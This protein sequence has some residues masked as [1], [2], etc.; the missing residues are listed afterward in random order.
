MKSSDLLEL[1]ELSLLDLIEAA[2]FE[3]GHSFRETQDEAFRAYYDYITSGDYTDSEKL[4]GFFEI[5]T[6][7]GKTGIISGILAG[8]VRHANIKS[9]DLNI[10]IIVPTNQLLGQTPTDIL[11]FSPSLKGKVGQY[12]DGEKDLAKSITVMNID[13]WDNLIEAKALSETSLDI[14]I[15]DEAHRG[16][17]VK[18]VERLDEGFS[19]ENNTLMLGFTATPDFNEKKSVLQTHGH[20]IYSLTLPEAIKKGRSVA[21]VSTRQP[22]IRIEPSDLMLSEKFAEASTKDRREYTTLLKERA[23]IQEA[24]KIYRDDIDTV[25][26]DPLIESKAAIFCN[27][28]RLAN[29]VALALNADPVLQKYAQQNGYDGFAVP[30]HSNKITKK[31]RKK[32]FI[33]VEQDRY[34]CVVGDSMFKEGFD[35]KDITLIIDTSRNSAVDKVQIL[36]RGARE[37]FNPDKE[38][39]EGLTAIDPIIYIGSPDPD[40]D[41]KLKEEAIAKYISFK[42]ILLGDEILGPAPPKGYNVYLCTANDPLPQSGNQDIIIQK[43][44]D[45]QFSVRL[46][47]HK[48][49]YHDLREC[50]EEMKVFL[51]NLVSAPKGDWEKQS[52]QEEASHY[53]RRRI[54]YNVEDDS[55][56]IYGHDGLGEDGIEHSS[57]EVSGEE[58]FVMSSSGSLMSLESSHHVKI[59]DEIKEKLREYQKRTKLGGTAIFRRLSFVPEGLN[60]QKTSHIVRGDAKSALS[61]HLFTILKEYEAVEEAIRN[62]K[63]EVMRPI[64]EAERK[65]IER[66]AKETNTLGTTLFKG[67]SNSP[68]GLSAHI[69]RNIVSGDTPKALPSHIKAI[70]DQYHTILKDRDNQANVKITPKINAQFKKSSDATG[71][72]G[73]VVHQHIPDCPEELTSGMTDHIVNGSIKHTKPAFIAAIA[74]GYEVLSLQ[75]EKAGTRPTE[76]RRKLTS[77]ERQRFDFL[78]DTMKLTGKNLFNLIEN[79]PD[80]MNDRHITSLRQITKRGTP[81][82]NSGLPSNIRIVLETLEA[83]YSKRDIAHDLGLG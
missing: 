22:I 65:E 27:N 62:N 10:V 59:T 76:K 61:S 69:T 17:S 54:R 6:G 25:T 5:A 23:F 8:V 11:K 49:N 73:Y 83:E 18:R 56:E 53:L 15:T 2:E 36:G 43:N 33:A 50:D 51:D 19:S 74:R 45:G 48:G 58:T 42:N 32:R 7:Q 1:I 67:M 72:T 24:V 29:D 30:I 26:G 80:T 79:P 41:E 55:L 75:Q 4:K 81:K 31:E 28:T 64:T 34:M 38:R 52:F 46:F 78:M 37:W 68:K 70:L 16:T 39:F 35:K 44:E 13:S 66:C 57:Y 20:K 12:G 82:S 47:D 60:A 40:M 71:A 3:S 14:V 9:L 21:Y 77:E 63:L